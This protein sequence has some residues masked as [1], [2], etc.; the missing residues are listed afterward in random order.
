MPKLNRNGVELYYEV[1]GEGPP[2]LLLHGGLCSNETWS[3]ILGDLAA[4][5]QVTAPE[6]RGHGRTPDIDQPITIESMLA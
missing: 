1:H 4:H 5:Y 3:G 2:L 6:R